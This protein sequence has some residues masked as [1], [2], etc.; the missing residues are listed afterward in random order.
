[1]TTSSGQTKPSHPAPQADGQS[2]P[3][4]ANRP[5]SVEHSTLAWVGPFATFAL[6]LAIDKYL[7]IANPAKELIRDAV[8]VLAIVAF[9]RRVLPRHA[10]HW[11]ASIAL[12]VAVSR[13]GSVRTFSFPDGDRIGCFRMA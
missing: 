2:P 7:P 11:A 4:D 13:Y 3:P 10:T 8:L 5:T 9:S 6:W 1:M 12:G